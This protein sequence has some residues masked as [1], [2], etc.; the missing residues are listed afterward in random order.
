MKPIDTF[1]LPPVPSLVT[2]LDWHETIKQFARDSIRKY[3]EESGFASHISRSDAWG[4]VVAV[5]DEVAPGW[6]ECKSTGAACAVAAIRKLAADAARAALAAQPAVGEEIMV[7][8]AHDVYTLPLQ[9]SGLDGQGPRF[10]VHVPPPE[11]QAAEI[12]ALRAEV[13]GWKAQHS[14]DSAELRRLC[15]HRDEYKARAERLA[16]AL[17]L[18][19]DEIVM[20]EHNPYEG[21]LMFCCG[22]RVTLSWRHGLIPTH[23]K[24]C[25]Y[26]RMRALRDHDQEDRNG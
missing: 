8:A 17:A 23:S 6:R 14:R 4:A 11:P 5:L 10:V 7:N 24:E 26:A 25:W 9:P 16:E 12:E 15:Q 21:P 3:V 13:D 20:V 19:P 1:E 22:R 2:S 18:L